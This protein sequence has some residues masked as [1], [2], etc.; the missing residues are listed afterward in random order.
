MFYNSSGEYNECVSHGACSVS[1][2]V[3]SMQEILYILFRQI[4]FYLV[5]LKSLG[6]NKTNIVDSLIQSI[7]LTDNIKD[8]TEVQI[9]NI[10]SS[11]YNTLI[12]CKNDYVQHCKDSNIKPK[13]IRNLI[14]LTPD[15]N[16][17]SLLNLGEKEF[18]NKYKN[19]NSDKK[20]LNEILISVI[21]SVS[22]STY[23]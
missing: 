4:A 3:S 11:L 10:F 21:K 19:I 12:N 22:Y 7:S 1:P 23:I 17:S 9:L 16:L 15:T 5:N 13:Y 18:I 20:Y 2:D 8:F 14:K 6:I